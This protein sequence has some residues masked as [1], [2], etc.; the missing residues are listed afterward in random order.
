MA[1]AKSVKVGARVQVTGT[2][3]MGFV[4]YVG[5][6]QFSSGKLV[7]FL[8]EGSEASKLGVASLAIPIPFN[9]YTPSSSN[10]LF[11]SIREEG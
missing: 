1:E 2:D 7:N 11:Q 10:G 6:T 5:T 9:C 4:A 8:V 3:V